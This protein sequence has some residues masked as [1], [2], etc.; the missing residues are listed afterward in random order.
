MTKFRVALSADFL[1]ADGSPAF[2]DF[3]LAPLRAD[4]RVEIGY[5][6]APGNVIPATA[7]EDYDALILF[8]FEMR[9]S[10]LPASGRLG[11]V[12]RFGVGYDSVDVEALADEGVAT[13]ITPGGV[14]RPVATGILA[15]ALALAGK[16]AAKDRLARRGAAGFAER[17]HHIGVGLMGKTVG[18]I[19]L[20]NIAIEMVGIMRPLGVGFIAHDPYVSE[21]VA[22]EHGVRLV[23]L[24]TLFAESDIVTVNCP[25]SPA[26]R[27]LVDAKRL[28]SMKP[29]AYLINTARGPIIDEAALAQ[30]LDDK[31]LAGA[32]LDVMSKEPPDPSPLFGRDNVL[33]TPHTS[34]YSEESLVELQTKAAEEVVA[35]LSGKAPRNPV[36][37]EALQKA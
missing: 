12:A 24:E 25:L 36:N 35:V 9:K 29:T 34:F 18:T 6:P 19:G 33:I 21:A 27:G 13:V 28:A 17:S 22:R 1:N 31:Q 15:F 26:T 16:I 23:G 3:D 11:V 37:P 2:P 7:L 8:A 30:A 10:S 4:P 20:G 14:A 32:A 5:V